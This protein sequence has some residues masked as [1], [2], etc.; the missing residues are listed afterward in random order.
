MESLNILW[1]IVP[2]S[3]GIIRILKVTV[4]GGPRHHRRLK[5]EVEVEGAKARIKD[6]EALC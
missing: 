6:K 5:I 1:Q 3:Q 4:E 2:L